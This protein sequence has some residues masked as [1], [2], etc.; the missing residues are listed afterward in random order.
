VK[1]FWVFGTSFIDG[2]DMEFDYE[3]KEVR[4]YT[5]NIMSIKKVKLNDSF[6]NV[7][8]IIKGIIFILSCNI[9]LIMY[10]KYKGL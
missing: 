2:F 1:D 3:F 4:F 9:C 6:D 8:S 7:Q 10:V 5:S